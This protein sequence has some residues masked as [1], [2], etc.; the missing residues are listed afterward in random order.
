MFRGIQLGKNTV[1]YLENEAKE[2]L[3]QYSARNR[4]RENAIVGDSPPDFVC[5][6]RVTSAQ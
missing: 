1:V 2:N 6:K 5:S 3:K 4:H